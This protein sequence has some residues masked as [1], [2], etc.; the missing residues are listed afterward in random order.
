[1]ALARTPSCGAYR[2]TTPKC[3]ATATGSVSSPRQMYDYCV[4][5]ISL[6]ALTLKK[7]I[8]KKEVRSC[9]SARKRTNVKYTVIVFKVAHNAQDMI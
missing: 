3:V 7:A 2:L 1:M 4:I 6:E 8:N 5:A 9:A